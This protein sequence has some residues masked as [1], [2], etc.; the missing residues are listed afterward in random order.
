M[1]SQQRTVRR[2]ATLADV[3]AAA[4]VSLST[5][6][7]CLRD[8]S[9]VRQVTS[10]RVHAAARALNYEPNRLARSLRLQ[11]STLIGIVVP[12]ISIGFYAR[13]VKGAQNVLQRAGFN[14]LVM[15]TDRQSA[16]DLVAI[17]MLVE[18]RTEGILIATSGGFEQRSTVPVVFFDNLIDGAGAAH[19]KRAN[20]EGVDLLVAHLVQHGHTRIAYV[21]APPLLTS[22]VERLSGFENAVKIRGLPAGNEFVALGDMNWSAESGARAMH[23]L[24][25][26]PHPPTAI[27][28]ASDNLALG[29][30]RAARSRGVRI[31]DDVAIVSFDDPVFADLFDPPVTAL[32]NTD[33]Q[34]GE[35]AATLLLHAIQTGSNGPPTEVR[36]PSEL[37]LRRSCGCPIVGSAPAL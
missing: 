7:R 5:A 13:T 8:S 23:M 18:H 25:D 22:G 10:Q 14:V 9:A 6:S 28:A 32:A 1:E 37:I 36:I 26:M 30:I 12:D 34:I 35:L 15:N 3:A 29:A 16:R 11:S 20:R 19:V 27:V 24:L 21:G 33:V 2:H 31:P 4:G 17:S